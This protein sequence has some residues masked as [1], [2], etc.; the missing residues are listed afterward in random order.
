MYLQYD[1]L[2][3]FPKRMKQVG[4]YALLIQNSSHS[5]IAR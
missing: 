5:E 4:L 3:Q 1:F 2:K